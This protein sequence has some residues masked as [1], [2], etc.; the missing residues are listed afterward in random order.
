LFIDYRRKKDA[1]AASLLQ[2][3]W[4]GAIN[5][6]F[7]VIT[8]YEL[9]FGIRNQK[10]SREHKILLHKLYRYPL[11]VNVARQ[12]AV[13]FRTY[14]N[15]GISLPDAIIAATAL[16]YGIPVCTRNNKHFK[17]IPGLRIEPY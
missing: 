13:I 14:G 2:K 10:E 16:R 15:I 8:D 1:A 6:G 7:S 4:G 5:A 9:W 12:A 17:N 3:A 11:T